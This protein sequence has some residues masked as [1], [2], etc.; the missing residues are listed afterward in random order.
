LTQTLFPLSNTAI[1]LSRL[2]IFSSSREL[3]HLRLL[4]AR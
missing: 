1:H 3:P 4:A 2:L